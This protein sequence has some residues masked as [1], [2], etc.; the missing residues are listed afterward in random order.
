MSQ[1]YTLKDINDSNGT[2]LGEKPFNR[3]PPNHAEL[4]EQLSR[5]IKDR[6]RVLESANRLTESAKRLIVKHDILDEENK[7]IRSELDRSQK[8]NE[9]I[10]AS[11][12]QSEKVNDILNDEIKHIQY[13]LDQTITERDDLKHLKSLKDQV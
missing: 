4:K 13:S 9:R 6:E 7:C 5:A 11:F 8:E 1:I 3:Y 2:K 10:Q 12:D